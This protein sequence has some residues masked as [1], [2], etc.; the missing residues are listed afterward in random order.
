M[1]IDA[2]REVGD[3]GCPKVGVEG[4]GCP[5]NE[6]RW[7]VAGA[8]VGRVKYGGLCSSRSERGPFVR[9]DS[10]DEFDGHPAWTYCESLLAIHHS[11]RL[12]PDHFT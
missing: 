8:E 1:V 4:G 10:T 5:K 3:A 9:F 2:Q 11:K 12:S 7:K 6:G